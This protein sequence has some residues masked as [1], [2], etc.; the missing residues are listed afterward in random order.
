[1]HI[2]ITIGSGGG[3]INEAEPPF[4]CITRASWWYGVYTPVT[5]EH[6]VNEP[7]LNL[8]SLYLAISFRSISGS[9]SNPSPGGRTTTS[10]VV[11]Y[12][13]V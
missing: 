6:A 8:R 7:I 4:S 11:S 2:N 12:Q 13:A 1:M 5:F 3:E 10:A 9:T